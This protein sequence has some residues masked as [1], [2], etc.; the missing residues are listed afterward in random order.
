MT[1]S[2][3]GGPA[4][5]LAACDH[6]LSQSPGQS[7]LAQGAATPAD[8]EDDVSRGD[9]DQVSAMVEAAQRQS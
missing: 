7:D 1:D 4:L 5:D 6:L 8:D 2:E 9:D 3:F